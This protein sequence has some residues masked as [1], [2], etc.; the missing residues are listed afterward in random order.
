MMRA[1]KQS[2]MTFQDAI[3]LLKQ[4]YLEQRAMFVAYD[5]SDAMHTS[6]VLSDAIIW[7]ERAKLSNVLP[8]DLAIEQAIKKVEAVGGVRLK[9]E[10][11]DFIEIEE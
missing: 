6:D 4:E 1:M 10:E 8:E 5:D 3:A 9:W 11:S 2:N 7:L